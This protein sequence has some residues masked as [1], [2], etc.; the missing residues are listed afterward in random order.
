MHELASLLSKFTFRFQP[1]V[2]L[3]SSKRAF[4]LVYSQQDITGKE[5]TGRGVLRSAL[6]LRPAND[7]TT[8]KL[9]ADEVLLSDGPFAETKDQ[10]GG[11][12][13]VECVDLDEALEVA[14][15]HPWARVGQIEVRPVWP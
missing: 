8:V 10:I 7:A 11:L 4:P 14:S 3:I 13:L 6:G 5:M 15:R 2:F 12:C 9:R 1:Q